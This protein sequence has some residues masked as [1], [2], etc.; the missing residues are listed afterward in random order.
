MVKT[1]IILIESEVYMIN[2]VS[3]FEKELCLKI[4]IN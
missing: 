2:V 3:L 4:F 1:R